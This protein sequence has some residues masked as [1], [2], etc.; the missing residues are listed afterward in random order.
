MEQVMKYIILFLAF[1]SV[2]ISDRI[3]LM[4]GTNAAATHGGGL[5]PDQVTVASSFT[6]GGDPIDENTGTFNITDTGGSVTI[7]DTGNFD[8]AQV[9]HYIYI[10]FTGDTYVD[11]R[12]IITTVD[13]SD[14][15]VVCNITYQA[16]D[17][18]NQASQYAVGGAIE[19]GSGGLQAVLDDSDFSAAAQQVS[20]YIYQA[21]AFVVTAT[22]D[23]DQGGG[24]GTLYMKKL[25]GV[26]SAYVPLTRGNYA[27][28]DATGTDLGGPIFE[29]TD[30]DGIGFYNIEVRDNDSNGGTPGAG[31]DGF[32]FN[33][34]GTAYSNFIVSNC[35]AD[36][37]YMGINGQ[38]GSSNRMNEMVIRDCVV[39]NMQDDAV[40]LSGLDNSITNT[41]MDSGSSADDL[42]CYY[43]SEVITG[44]VFAG[45]G[46]YGIYFPNTGQSAIIR[47]CTFYNHTTASIGAGTT[48]D[49]I[50]HEVVNNLFW[51]AAINSDPVFSEGGTDWVFLYE[52]Y[53]YTN[54]DSTRA[55]RLTGANSL[56]TQWSDT[57][58]NL[59]VAAG[60][61]NFTL[62]DGA[63]AI[64]S[65]LPT[66]SDDGV[67]PAGGYM[68]IGAAQL[69][70]TQ[71]GGLAIPVLNSTNVIR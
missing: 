39:Q 68:S 22:I 43:G 51:V 15:Y 60:S 63:N 9:G 46:N 30:L 67:T 25:V 14:N 35:K 1:V 42:Y 6:S 28:F 18:T 16:G 61:D 55:A 57:E 2:C 50:L 58:S 23:F 69:T 38:A 71:S 37:C 24:T 33:S 47:N 12:A 21:S 32:A 53:N 19:E 11:G 8:G 40:R 3:V 5:D 27:A 49:L 10:T 66:R 17:S 20:V 26:S 64:D 36:N 13:A 45:G 52:D 59:W 41:F 34:T 48:R 44:C 65:G 62:A 29:V 54:A 7:T 31:E 4:G 70:Q 56:N